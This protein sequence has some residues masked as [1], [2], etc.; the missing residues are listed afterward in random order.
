MLDK[1]M[2][3]NFSLTETFVEKLKLSQLVTFVFL[4]ACYLSYGEH[5][6]EMLSAVVVAIGT[7]ITAG[8]LIGV[9]H[10]VFHQSLFDEAAYTYMQFPLS[11][12]A[13]VKG[14]LL[15]VLYAM[16]W[17]V[18]IFSAMW[19]LVYLWW[20]DLNEGIVPWDLHVVET[21]VDDLH[22]IGE[23]LFGQFFSLRA[24]AFIFGSFVVQLVLGCA[25]L[26]SGIQLGVI[27]NHVHNRDGRQ[28]YVPLLLLLVGTIIGAACFYVPTKVFCVVTD[29]FIT[30]L[31]ILV[32]MGMEIILI[33]V[34]VRW[35]IRL[36]QTKYE[37][38]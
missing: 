4:S 24:T 11:S 1:S 34:A 36:L 16:T 31:P 14:K 12:S 8:I 2:T 22:H 23:V 13:V 33:I 19:L 10:R 29:E 35:S 6:M 37:L 9:C 27:L 3:L 15:A 17:N 20:R 38:N 30:L 26:C 25:L 7:G 5:P 18:L 32:T 28:K 21:L